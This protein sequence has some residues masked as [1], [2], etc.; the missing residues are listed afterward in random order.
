LQL[1]FYFQI[2]STWCSIFTFKSEF[3]L[4]QRFFCMD[5]ACCIACFY[6]KNRFSF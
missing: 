1:L 4:L 5:S 6:I 3:S 2:C